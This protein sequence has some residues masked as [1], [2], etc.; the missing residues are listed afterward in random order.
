M[1]TLDDD[2]QRAV[3]GTRATAGAL[4]RA[5]QKRGQRVFIVFL[6][7]MLVGIYGM[8]G[9]VWPTLKADLL[10]RGADVLAQTPFDVILLQVKI[11]LIVGVL[12]S[13]PLLFYYARGGLRERGVLRDVPVSRTKAAVV[14]VFAVLLF[15]GGIAY[16]Y[17]LFFPI[18][19]TF[20][21]HNSQA[22]GFEPFYSIIDWTEFILVL[23]LSFGLAA[24]L[25]LAMMALSYS[26][27][28]PYEAFRDNWKY[29]V[30]A[31]FAFGALFS[32][33]DPFTQILWAFPLVA[34]YGISLYITKIV[35]TAK[36]AGDTVS[37]WR[38]LAARWN[39]LAGAGVVGGV[40]GYALAAANLH[41]YA[42][43]ALASAGSSYRI[44]S[45]SEALGMPRGTALFVAAAVVGV[46]VLVA[47]GFFAVMRAY[48]AA[49]AASGVAAQFGDPTEINLDALDA[50]GVRA[51]PPE[52]FVAMSEDEALAAANRAVE[53]DEK[54]KARLILDRFDEAEAEREEAAKEAEAEEEEG[55]ML[56]GATADIVNP[57][58]EEETT[59]DDIG[60]Y[61]HD[62]TFILDSI[63][64]GLFVIA[65]TFMTV[66]AV[67]FYWLYTGGIGDIRRDFLARL[68]SEV[69]SSEP[70]DIVTLH[71]VEALVFEV[72]ISTIFA[73]IV[74]LP[75]I[76]YYAWPAIEERGFVN[77]DQRG[78]LVWGG[79]LL[80][81][82]FGGIAIGYAFIAPNIIS[83]FV[84]DA[85]QADMEILYRVK[86]FFW[87]VFLTTAGIG[88]LFDIPMTM[89]LFERAGY[90]SY[91]T[92]RERWRG[93]ALFA[94][95]FAGVATPE[96][97]YSLFVIAVPVILFYW[98]GLGLLWVLTLGGRRGKSGRASEEPTVT[99]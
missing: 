78:M 39:H 77:G 62:I 19:F 89:L 5:A 45:V 48:D 85:V 16:A 60:G 82:L 12:F 18:M 73:A 7:G 61:Y 51:A 52:A 57:L 94:F 24:Q 68:P 4:L 56:T 88:I 72:K 49:V 66:L 2:A 53:D 1:V 81:G 17:S 9:F 26:G 33:P 50:T 86:S 42:N 75:L 40:V 84:W 74:C 98:V 35:V 41:R 31:V 92:L 36:R 30:V 27:V 44:P 8:R 28:V 71:P 14:F 96:S 3:S 79:A 87:L 29:A 80:M 25:P 97:V 47:A 22:A 15:L 38:A 64:S 34:L 13:L 69:I 55:G 23:G 43:D 10:A 99:P 67:T 70:L 59:E 21:A 20:L 91:A 58:T 11:G 65:G 46:V 93:V 95:A 63:R 6:V 83:W 76:A 32:P 90:I 37:V 54:E